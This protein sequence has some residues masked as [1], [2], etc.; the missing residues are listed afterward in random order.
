MVTLDTPAST[1]LD[2]LPLEVNCRLAIIIV[3]VADAGAIE[4][5]RRCCKTR[6]FG[7]RPTGLEDEVVIRLLLRCTVVGFIAPSGID[8]DN[9]PDRMA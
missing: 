6:P 3:D 4:S 8:T 2:G 9:G 7:V 1:W 5:I